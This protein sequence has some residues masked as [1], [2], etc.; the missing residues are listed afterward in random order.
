MSESAVRALGDALLVYATRPQQSVPNK[1]HNPMI[2]EA[3]MLPRIVMALTCAQIATISVAQAN[4]G[5]P[6]REPIAAKVFQLAQLRMKLPKCGDHLEGTAAMPLSQIPLEFQILYEEQS[7][8]ECFDQGNSVLAC[9]H[10]RRALQMLDAEYPY[11][12]DIRATVQAIVRR[13][14]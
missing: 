14:N 4:T 9:D 13:C 7:G 8:N 2:R 12:A 11:Q 1:L 5:W 10:Y 6:T 3:K